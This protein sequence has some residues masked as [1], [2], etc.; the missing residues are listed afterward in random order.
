LIYSSSKL[1]W[2]FKVLAKRIFMKKIFAALAIVTAMAACNS[3]TNKEAEIQQ[4]KQYTI[5]SMKNAAIL[6]EAEARN[7]EAS[8]ATASRTSTKHYSSGSRK[9]STYRSYSEPGTL[10]T[11]SR[12]AHDRPGWNNKAKGAVIGGVVGAVTG[13]AVSKD[14][15]GKG[16]VIGGVVGAAGG[17][18]VGAILDKK[19]KE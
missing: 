14:K 3:N 7:A 13:A 17:Y 11:A 10:P 16:A 18:G 8:R 1:A 4:A 15:K 6:Q 9:T 2:S 5:D 12:D 19:K